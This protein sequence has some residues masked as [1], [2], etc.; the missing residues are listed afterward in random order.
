M[1]APRVSVSR[2]DELHKRTT[3]SKGE[4]PGSPF[5]LR[6]FAQAT[7][8]S[9]SQLGKGRESEAR[10]GCA[11]KMCVRCAGSAPR[12]VVWRR[13]RL[14]A[15]AVCRMASR[16]REDGA[17]RSA[18]ASS[19]LAVNPGRSSTTR[20]NPAGLSAWSA[21]PDD[22]LSPAKSDEGP[23]LPFL[24][25]QMKSASLPSSSSRSTAS[26]ALVGFRY[27]KPPCRRCAAVYGGS[28]GV[29]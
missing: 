5:S 28:G 10:F 16:L 14:E 17:F 23:R 9:P 7:A 6:P 15:F 3:A 2:C 12:A 13:R 11:R 21:F 8:A 26:P 18:A 19:R 4:P 20:R 25:E 1:S 24:T 27:L 22:A 29:G